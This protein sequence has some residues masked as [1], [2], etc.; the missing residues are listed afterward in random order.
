MSDQPENEPVVESDSASQA[1]D[2]ALDFAVAAARLAAEYK[3]E[4][5]EILDLRG[6]SSFTDFFVLGTGTSDR[7]MHAVLGILEEYA[8]T[9]DRAPF[10][11]ADSRSAHWILADYVDVI[12][13]LFDEQHRDYYDLANLWG[14]APRIE[15]QPPG[16]TPATTD[17]D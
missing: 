1:Y 15:W 5:V 11:V 7:Q 13:H 9:I 14:D 3:T 17:P 2:D 10:K 16:D 6:L 4:D 8:K 12:V